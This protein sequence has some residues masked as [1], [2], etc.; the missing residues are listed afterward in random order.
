VL[1][2]ASFAYKLYSD[3]T[4]GD[5]EINVTSLPLGSVSA[6]SFVLGAAFILSLTVLCIYIIKAANRQKLLQKDKIFG[7]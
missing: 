3:L 6:T 2:G 5:E 1:F 4:V 7:E